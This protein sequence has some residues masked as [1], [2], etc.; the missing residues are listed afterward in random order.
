VRLLRIHTCALSSPEFV[1]AFEKVIGFETH[2][3]YLVDCKLW[4]TC[5]F[6]ASVGVLYNGDKKRDGVKSIHLVG[7]DGL[8]YFMTGPYYGARHDSGCYAEAGLSHI[9]YQLWRDY[10]VRGYGDCFPPF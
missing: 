8:C 9:T 5:D 3:A 10:H 2:I 1:E 6:D 4:E 7:P